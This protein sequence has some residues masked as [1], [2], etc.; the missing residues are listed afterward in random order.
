MSAPT[1]ATV[2]PA[3]K[4]IGTPAVYQFSPTGAGVGKSFYQLKVKLVSGIGNSDPADFFFSLPIETRMVNNVAT[5]QPVS[6]DVSSALRAVAEQWQPEPPVTLPDNYPAVSF[7]M[8]AH[9]EWLIEGITYTS[10]TARYPGSTGNVYM[11]MGAL[12]DRERLT[13]ERPAKYGR[14]PSSS[15]EICFIGSRVIVPGTTANDAPPSIIHCVAGE[16]EDEEVFSTLNYYAVNR[17]AD[18]Y[19]IRFINS[20][21]VH[22]NIFVKGFPDIKGGI[23][24]E[25]Y[26]LSKQETLTKFSRGLAVKQNDH[27]RWNMT[28]GPVDREWASWFVHEFLMVRWAWIN[29]NGNYIPCHIIPEEEV[30]LRDDKTASP[31]EIPFI[32]ELDITGSPLV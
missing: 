4:F 15:P 32:V 27:E 22:E 1:I 2:S 17:P 10:D 18:G 7:F 6:L 30:T 29:I 14:K 20:L 5:A 21:G 31:L 19:E 23:Q 13:G 12:T 28:S 8:E 26:V 3:S 16:P 24:T 25:R 11:Y 9:E